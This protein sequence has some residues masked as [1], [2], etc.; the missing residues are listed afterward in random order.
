MGQ[1]IIMQVFGTMFSGVGFLVVFVILIP[2]L[3]IFDLQSLQWDCRLDV[4]LFLRG[5]S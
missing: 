1:K 4:N 3:P 2:V 5:N